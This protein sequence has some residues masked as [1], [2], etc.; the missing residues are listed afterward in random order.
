MMREDLIYERLLLESQ[1]L[2]R[3][4]GGLERI[5]AEASPAVSVPPESQ[6]ECAIA[7][8]TQKSGDGTI[9]LV[10]D[11][12]LVCDLTRRMLER[13]GFR[14]LTAC[15]GQTALQTFRAHQDEVVCALLDLTMP[16]MDGAETLR[17]LRQ[18][19]ADLPAVVS[20]G[21]DQTE[22]DKRLEGAERCDFVQKPYEL[23]V[24]RNTLH[25]VLRRG[26]A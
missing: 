8:A 9:L 5:L 10:D 4:P 19:K 6:A 24:L 17:E 20:S 3:N 26:G 22:L 18:I 11:E 23:A 12:E 15:D 14:V 25:Q 1:T 21:Y 13:L 2:Q 7:P 16:R